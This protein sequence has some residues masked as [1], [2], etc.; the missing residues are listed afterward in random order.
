MM[1]VLKKSGLG[2]G[3]GDLF[4]RTDDDKAEQL[5][6]GSTFADL[7]LQQI[8]PNPHQPRTVFDEDDLDKAA[9]FFKGKGLPV[10]WVERPYQGR[11]FRTRDPMGIPLEFYTKM[12]RLPPIHQKYAL[13][14]QGFCKWGLAI[15]FDFLH[16]VL[17]L[18]QALW[19]FDSQLSKGIL[20]VV[21][22]GH[23]GGQGNIV[24]FAVYCI[25]FCCPII[26]VVKDI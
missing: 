22:T 19:Y 18:C 8:S 11:T 24:D 7:P 21:D 13:Y 26:E 20:V 1:A 14:T 9:H 25:G 5:S 23:V 17:E 4:A 16:D 10:D 6:D 2:Q 3:L 12:D 15:I